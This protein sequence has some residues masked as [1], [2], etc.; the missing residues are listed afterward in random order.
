ME[1]NVQEI[2]MLRMLLYSVN[3]FVEG[4]EEP[5]DDVDF[6]RLVDGS[7]ECSF[8]SSELSFDDFGRVHIRQRATSNNPLKTTV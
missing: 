2:I 7:F 1:Y 4:E 3:G 8:E 6:D 5:D